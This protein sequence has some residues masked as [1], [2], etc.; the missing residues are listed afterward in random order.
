MK[1]IIKKF[2]LMSVRV[3]L[4]YPECEF[5]IQIFLTCIDFELKIFLI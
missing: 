5:T 3:S 4:E 2:E 1:K